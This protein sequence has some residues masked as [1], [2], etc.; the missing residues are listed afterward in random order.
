MPKLIRDR[1]LRQEKNLDNTK[2]E[3]SDRIK[4]ARFLEK[5][6]NKKGDEL[7]F[8]K[9]DSFRMKNEIKDISDYTS[10]EVKYNITNNW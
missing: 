5:R 1:I 2:N 7:L 10:H 4:T 8:N 9:N 6:T 3:Q